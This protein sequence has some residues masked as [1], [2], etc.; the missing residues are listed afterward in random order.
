MIL[1]VDITPLGMIIIPLTLCFFLVKPPYL[2]PLL[3]SVSVLHAGSVL[4][5]SINGFQFGVPPYYFVAL[6]IFARLCVVLIFKKNY[7]LNINV[8]LRILLCLFLF[9]LWAIVSS[10]LFPHI[11][12]G[13]K[14]YN[15]RL[16]LAMQYGQGTP[17]NWTLSNLAQAIYLTLNIGVIVYVLYAEENSSINYIINGVLIAVIIVGMLGLCQTL[18]SLLDIEFPYQ[19]INNNIAYYQGY[20]QYIGFM[21]RL[22]CSFTEPSCA[23]TYLASVEV[24]LLSIYL[25]NS[26]TKKQEF[27][28]CVF[29]FLYLG[30]LIRTLA[31]TGYVTL[32]VSVFLLIFY[33]T[34]LHSDKR[35]LYINRLSIYLQGS[36]IV[37][38]IVAVSYMS[39]LDG[40]NYDSSKNIIDELFRIINTLISSF[41][42][43]KSSLSYIHRTASDLHALKVFISTNG[44]G[45]GLGSSRSSS[46]IT[47]LL[48][49]VG[50]IGVS[51]FSA[52]VYYILKTI[53]KSQYEN[54]QYRNIC[55]FVF[56]GLLTLIIAHCISIPDISFP[57]TWAY[58]IS[59]LT[60]IQ[61]HLNDNYNCCHQLGSKRG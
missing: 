61:Y 39:H 53:S 10:F 46:L 34:I 52:F 56:W 7:S 15:P 49:T 33:N 54:P 37:F 51:L 45:V 41:V 20:D 17:L 31:T 28:I 16:G 27:F 22:V 32:L 1:N 48:S 11:F 50:I 29:I 58:L 23:S 57:P 8:P 59:S 60:L 18:F 24:G 9:W 13:M 14:V 3:L 42:K 40:V 38:I 47:T 30:L 26:L 4:N 35:R 5:G 21:R 12:Q 25:Y 36:I 44:L 6:I 43:D 2:L 19:L 55:S